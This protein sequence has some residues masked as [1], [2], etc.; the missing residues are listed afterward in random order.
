MYTDIF[1]VELPCN[2]NSKLRNNP[3]ETH[4]YLGLTTAV[5]VKHVQLVYKLINLF[6][7]CRFI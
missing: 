6:E 1:F 4:Y 2:D 5:A 3:V 7:N